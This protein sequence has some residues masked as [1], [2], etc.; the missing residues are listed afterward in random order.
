[1]LALIAAIFVVLV[2]AEVLVERHVVLPSFAELERS[3]ARTAMRRIGQA[4]DE[5]TVQLRREQLAVVR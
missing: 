5:L 1:M 3:D 4:L 2:L